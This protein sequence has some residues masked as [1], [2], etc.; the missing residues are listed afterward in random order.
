[1]SDAGPRIDE[2]HRKELGGDWVSCKD[3]PMLRVFDFHY[4]YCRHLGDQTKPDKWNDGWFRLW[5]GITHKAL[6]EAPCKLPIQT[7]PST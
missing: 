3:C 7:P 4:F 5:S 1:M 6:D 2:Y